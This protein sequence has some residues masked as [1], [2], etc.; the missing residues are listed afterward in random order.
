[1]VLNKNIGLWLSLNPDIHL[2]APELGTTMLFDQLSPD[3]F[4]ANSPD[5]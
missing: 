5:C 1:M 4:R 3:H 2:L